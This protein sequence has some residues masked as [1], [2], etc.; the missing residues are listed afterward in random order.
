MKN[1]QGTIKII[2]ILLAVFLAFTISSV[3][4]MAKQEVNAGDAKNGIYATF[5]PIKTDGT[6]DEG[7][8]REAGKDGKSLILKEDE[9]GN[10]MG[11]FAKDIP[12]GVYKVGYYLTLDTVEDSDKRVRFKPLAEDLY[13]NVPYIQLID[14]EGEKVLIVTLVRVE[15]DN[16]NLEVG[17]WKDRGISGTLDKIVIV[18]HDYN[19][20]AGSPDYELIAEDLPQDTE[21]NAQARGYEHPYEDEWIPSDEAPDPSETATPEAT[22]TPGDATETPGATSPAVTAT[23][24]GT[25]Y[26]TPTQT[27]DMNDE[28]DDGLS[29]WLV[30]G[31]LILLGAGGAILY[32]FM[33]NK[34]KY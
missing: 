3:L 8:P 20:I 16:D 12:E 6:W 24:D 25:T 18:S 4:I 34:N 32:F 29:M 30:I 10:I 23:P 31:I 28:E 13:Y 5:D 26:A 14:Y 17:L 9:A 11:F 21:P 1:L 33:K 19:F 22:P 27:P 2:L 7:K 15:E